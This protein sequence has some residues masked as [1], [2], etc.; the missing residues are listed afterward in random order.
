[1]YNT[2]CATIDKRKGGRDWKTVTSGSSH[3][4]PCLTLSLQIIFLFNTVV[5]TTALKKFPAISDVF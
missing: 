2:L 5:T 1:M 3:V 4:K